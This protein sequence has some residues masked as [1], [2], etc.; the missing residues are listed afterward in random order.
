MST[1]GLSGHVRTKGKK[2]SKRLCPPY[3]HIIIFYA[4]EWL[5]HS[6]LCQSR[7]LNY[8]RLVGE[9]LASVSQAANA[10]WLNG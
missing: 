2:S 5:P 10:K 6:H 4:V 9:L 7:V 3:D 8:D 1:A